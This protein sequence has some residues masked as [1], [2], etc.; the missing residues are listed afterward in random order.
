VIK[1][2]PIRKAI[3]VSL[4]CATLVRLGCQ[5]YVFKYLR[6]PLFPINI[7]PVASKTL[8]KST[9]NS[10]ESAAMLNEVEI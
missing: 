5:Y 4:F 7:V 10:R 6:F 2:K 8:T 9:S 1:P 3:C